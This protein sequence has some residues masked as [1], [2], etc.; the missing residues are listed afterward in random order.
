MK[1]LI[2]ITTPYFF[3][4]EG[5][6]LSN[7]FREGMG[8]LHLRKPDCSRSALEKLILEIPSQYYSRIV[9]HDQFGLVA[10]GN[11]YH[12]KGI[13]LN[14]RNNTIPNGFSGSISCSCHSLQEISENAKFD[15]RFLSPIFQSISKQGYG[16]GFP[17]DILWQASKTGLINEKVIALGGI[18][19]STIPQLKDI[20]FGG[21]A[22][23]GALWGQS[24]S[25]KEVNNIIKRFK[26]LE[27]CL[28]IH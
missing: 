10:N 7:L 15:Y 6:I 24:P 5:E 4:G 19:I 16:N 18:D 20:V 9:L 26:S 2:V 22:V 23:L 1:K 17:L 3:R 13:H 25:E 28:A 14:R 12:F 11:P 27:L 8:C 21:V